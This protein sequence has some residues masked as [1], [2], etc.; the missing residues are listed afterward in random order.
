MHKVHAVPVTQADIHVTAALTGENYDL[1]GPCIIS[2]EKGLI[3]GIKPA[4][5]GPERPLLAMPSLA[6]AHNHGRPLSTTSFGCGGKPLELWLPHLA[7][8]PSIDPYTAAAASFSRSLKGGATAIMVHLT[9]PMG[10]TDLPQEAREISRAARDVGVQ[11]GFAISMRDRNP[12]TYGNH[13]PLLERLTAEQRKLAEKTWLAPLPSI[14]DQLDLVDAVADAI[15]DAS[16][17][18][19]VQ[20]GPTGVQWCSDALLAAIAD[21]SAQ[22]GRRIHMHLLETQ[23]Q[24]NWADQNYPGG[25]VARLAELN[26]LSPRLTLAHCVWARPDEL[27]QIAQ[28]NARIAVNV[29]SNLHLFSGVANVGA[30]LDAGIEV[31][32]GLDGCALDE[33]DDGLREL[34][35]FHLLNHPSGFNEGGLDW[36]LALRSAC[37]NGRQ[38][39]GLDCGGSLAPGM[40][41]D[42]VCLDLQ[43]LNRD[44][45]L[46]VDPMQLLFARG[47][48]SHIVDIYAQGRKVVE[49]GTVTGVDA[50]E[51]ENDLRQK[52]RAALPQ[53]AALRAI[54]PFIETGI[55]DHYRGCC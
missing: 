34:R 3:T 49:N 5:S 42:F 23:P 30:M 8:I 39:L 2:T 7:A 4:K 33:D 48:R 52:Y 9:R 11:I 32:M 13:Q 43:A 18:V 50:E 20:Y 19:N 15:A 26:F 47:T 24:R 31:G 14:Q 55:S 37:A 35:L 28:H 17:Y 54:W 51:I 44:G 29:S 10:L 6:D 21:R 12:L 40:P 53:T 27:T 16:D 36:A 46:D 45:I 38:S 25:I 1:A 41:A 22:S